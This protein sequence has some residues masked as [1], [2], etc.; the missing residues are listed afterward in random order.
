MSHWT[1]EG[2]T[3]F[4][5]A[6][7]T[8][9]V[10]DLN[11]LLSSIEMGTK[12]LGERSGLGKQ[13]AQSTLE[14]VLRWTTEKMVFWARTAGLKVS[15]VVYDDGDPDNE[16]GPVDSRCFYACWKKCGSPRTV[17]ELLKRDGDT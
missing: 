11:A 9:Y 4:V 16:K 13:A 8:S 7:V 5:H 1:E 3:A 17:K 6:L 12:E 2:P 10:R 15:I 14:N